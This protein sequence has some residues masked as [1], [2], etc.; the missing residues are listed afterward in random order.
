MS[1]CNGFKASSASDSPMQYDG[2][3]SHY[4]PHFSQRAAPEV[5][6]ID[7]LSISVYMEAAA[8]KSP[9]SAKCESHAICA[10]SSSMGCRKS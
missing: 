5:L 2:I 10:N 8:D 1:S 3:I 9:Q 6:T 7:L 4:L